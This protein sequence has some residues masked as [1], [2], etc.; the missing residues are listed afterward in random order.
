MPVVEIGQRECL[1]Q[2]I[3]AIRV[4]SARPAGPADISNMPPQELPDSG[5]SITQPA[6]ARTGAYQP[7]GMEGPYGR[8][9]KAGSA[10]LLPNGQLSREL[11]RRALI[12]T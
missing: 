5:N 3:A 6:I 8:L 12:V 7:L 11:L 4:A 10:L 1:L 9:V 2:T